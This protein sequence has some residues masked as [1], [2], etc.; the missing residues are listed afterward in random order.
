MLEVPTLGGFVLEI[1][2]VTG[3]GVLMI[4][5]GM[6]PGIRS[7][8]DVEYLSDDISMVDQILRSLFADNL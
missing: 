7:R 8:E 4:R 5:R 3:V 2:I 1:V 6:T